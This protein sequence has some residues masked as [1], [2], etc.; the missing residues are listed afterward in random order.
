MRIKNQT[1]SKQEKEGSTLERTCIEYEPEHL[2][3]KGCRYSAEFSA[4]FFSVKDKIESEGGWG[5][6]N[7]RAIDFSYWYGHASVQ[8]CTYKP[9]KFDF[10]AVPKIGSYSGIGLKKGIGGGKEYS[11]KG[12]QEAVLGFPG[13]YYQKIIEKN[14]MIHEENL[15]DWRLNKLLFQ[16]A[17]DSHQYLEVG[18]PTLHSPVII[19]ASWKKMGIINIKFPLK[20]DYK[21]A[22][23][24]F[25][26]DK[27]RQN[28]IVEVPRIT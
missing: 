20:E 26:M 11:A 6:R 21:E 28:G 3:L 14:L 25:D 12:L 27:L 10:V 15:V 2:L 9:I 7:V 18:S 24:L 23:L 8:E 5:E 17:L 1:K 22:G 4:S 19:P 13:E 16:R